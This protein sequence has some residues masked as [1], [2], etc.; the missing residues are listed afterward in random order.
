M[1]P[2]T[3]QS[4]FPRNTKPG[5]DLKARQAKEVKHFDE[6]FAFKE[7]EQNIKGQM[8][9]G[10]NAREGPDWTVEKCKEMSVEERK[11]R[12]RSLIAAHPGLC[13]GPHGV[14]FRHEDCLPLFILSTNIPIPKKTNFVA[15]IV[16]WETTDT[17]GIP[18][19][20]V[21][22]LNNHLDSNATFDSFAV[23]GSSTSRDNVC[24]V[25]EKGK[26]FILAMQ[27]FFERVESK[28]PELEG[29]KD[30]ILPLSVSFRVGEQIGL[31]KWKKSRR[32]GAQDTLRLVLEDLTTRTVP[33]YLEHR[34]LLDIDL[35][36]EGGVPD[37]YDVKLETPKMKQ[38]ATKILAQ[39]KTQRNKYGLTGPDGA[40]LVKDDEV[41]ISV[42]GLDIELTPKY[43]FSAIYGI[44][45]PLQKWRLQ[46]VQFFLLG[47]NESPKFYHRDQLV[48]DS[49]TRLKTLSINYHGDLTLSSDRTSVWKDQLWNK[50]ETEV[51]VSVDLAICTQPDLAVELA[52]EILSID[53]SDALA[54]ILQPRNKRG[55]AE[56]RAAFETA[57]RRKHPNTAAATR[58]QPAT[59][60]EENLPLYKELNLE[61]FMVTHRVQESLHASGAYLPV[62]EY[63]RGSLFASP[64]VHDIKGL[65]Q[66]RAATKILLPHIRS[67]NITVRQY[68]KTYPIAVLDNEKKLIACALPRSREDHPNERPHWIGPALQAVAEDYQGKKIDPE[69]IFVAFLSCMGGG[70]STK[71]AVPPATPMA[72]DNP[73]VSQEPAT[74]TAHL[75]LWSNR[76]GANGAAAPK[77]SS[78]T[79][80]HPSQGPPP[81]QTTNQPAAQTGGMPPN[82]HST[83][84]Q[85]PQITPPAQTTNRI[86]AEN[87]GIVPAHPVQ[88]PA[89]SEPRIRQ[90][91]D[92]ESDLDQRAV[93]RII[94]AMASRDALRREIEEFNVAA[95]A[96]DARIAKLE[97][98]NK[99][100][101]E[102]NNLFDGV[103]ALMEKRQFKRQ[104]GD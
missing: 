36:D 37:H 68:S 83:T 8:L 97:E 100:L 12:K 79:A 101:L 104:R 13:T 14:A 95:A 51:G 86:A 89:A 31:L 57:V 56:Y 67:E 78:A 76:P 30:G 72:I 4:W 3:L 19:M 69:M 38:K 66:F 103:A 29:P 88:R 93:N 81:A 43:L 2:I 47:P 49:P 1:P 20:G 55:G 18:M 21:S 6:P 17:T 22:F 11:E 35:A 75:R 15:A 16:L 59:R 27:Y 48:P 26:G 58:L 61:P 33:E 25:G 71:E 5:S 53:R 70:D 50:Y 91:S 32:A 92:Q 80:S 82:L 62:K 7:L 60:T 99:G 23:D 9:K 73:P 102:D 52:D 84:S 24:A 90:N 40:S 28:R 85:P 42:M 54:G 98:E 46:N 87:R 45:P 44:F 34:Y 65:D 74:N 41:C 64:V 96:K 39:A 63:A 94:Q 10:L 77:P